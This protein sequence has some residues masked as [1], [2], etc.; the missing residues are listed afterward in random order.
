MRAL[1]TGATGFVGSHVARVL[2]EAGW[3]VRALVRPSSNAINIRGLDLEPIQGDIREP[4]SVRR[5]A[6]GCDAVFHVAAL[7]AFWSRDSRQ[8]Y[9]TN[10]EGTRNVLLAAREAGV[11]R[12]VYTSTWA[13][14]GGPRQGSLADEESRPRPE[15]LT[16]PYR[17]T[18]YQAEQVAL[19]SCKEGLDVVVV[20]PT[21][22]VGP[23]DARP[24]PT[25]RVVLDFLR[26]RLPAYVNTSVNLIAVEDVA[27]GHRL[28]YEKGKPGERYILG[29][30]NV[31]LKAMLDTLAEI[32]VKSAPR[33]R[34]P[35]GL[36]LAG[37]Y[38]DYLLEG[39]LLRRE[40]LIPLEGVQHARRYMAADS[41]KAVREL[42]LPQ[43]PVRD[44][45]ARAVDW[46]Y[47]HDYVGGRRAQ[48]SAPVG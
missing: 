41:S 44:A 6:R 32:T 43:T 25:G 19:A 24:T 13:V 11:R 27:Q 36:A 20:N 2:L 33:W 35:L 10:V 18:K 23:G 34:V 14:L 22:P 46:F 38:V 9:R 5:A 1:V 3:Q 8:F 39:V 26:G 48:A 45:L 12:V 42:G 17:W 28:A 37:A 16:G 7:Y 31:T 30:Q 29:N 21:V 47:E 4:E 40:P 15:E